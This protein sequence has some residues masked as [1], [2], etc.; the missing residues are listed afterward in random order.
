MTSTRLSPKAITMKTLTKL[1]FAL[2]IVLSSIETTTGQIIK[3]DGSSTVYPI[4]K[5]ITHYYSKANPE[6]SV[7]LNVSGT[8]GGLHKF[9]SGVT[10]INN[11]SRRLNDKELTILQNNGIYFYELPI[12]TDGLAVVVNKTNTF[13]ESL[14]LEELRKIWEK[15]STIKYWNDLRETFPRVPINLY[16]PGD[17]SGTQDYF[18]EVITGKAHNLRDDYKKSEDDDELV[19]YILNDANSISFFGL[20]YYHKNERQLNVISIDAGEGPVSPTFANVKNGVYRPLSRQLYLHI[21]RRSLMRNDVIN[22]LDYYLKNLTKT[23]KMAGYI[24]LSQQFYSQKLDEIKRINAMSV[25][26]K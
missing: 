22:Y 14:T 24:P 9:T 25:V 4:T 19:N 2:V 26:A 15:G 7:E 13:V 8:T 18:S 20:A 10:D 5:T 3:I 16:G 23:T 21:N 6:I 1:C 17:E 12:A 11:S